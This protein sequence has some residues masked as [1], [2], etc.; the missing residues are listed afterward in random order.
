MSN[1]FHPFFFEM[2]YGIVSMSTHLIKVG[3]HILFART[4][5]WDASGNPQSTFAGVALRLERGKFPRR[6]VRSQTGE[7]EPVRNT[8]KPELAMGCITYGDPILGVD[9]HPFATYF[10]VHQGCRVLTHSQLGLPPF[11]LFGP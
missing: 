3:H 9:E 7:K 4:C 1:P 2:W 10:D 8:R 6:R 11:P 5:V